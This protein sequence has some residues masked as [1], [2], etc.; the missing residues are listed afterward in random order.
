[1]LIP[2]IILITLTGG[3]TVENKKRVIDTTINQLGLNE[4]VK[5]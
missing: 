3:S 1:M 2:T 4:T 5:D